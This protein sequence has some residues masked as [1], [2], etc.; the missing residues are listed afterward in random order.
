MFVDEHPVLER[1]RLTERIFYSRGG[2]DVS[3][4]WRDRFDLCVRLH[5]R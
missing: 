5:R 1:P 2:G 3:N 4:I